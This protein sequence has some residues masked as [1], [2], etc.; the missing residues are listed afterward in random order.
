MLSHP[1]SSTALADNNNRSI[2]LCC[3]ISGGA[4][5]EAGCVAH[6]NVVADATA[7]AVE[8]LILVMFVRSSLL[9]GVLK[10]CVMDTRFVQTEG[11]STL[12]TV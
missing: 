4:K 12:A 11:L 10:N 6:M 2:D 7:A 1:Q 8:N 3:V 5:H 9:P